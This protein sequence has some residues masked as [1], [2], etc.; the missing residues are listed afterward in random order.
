MH[1][2]FTILEWGQ[3]HKCLYTAKGKLASNTKT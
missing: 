2:L 1:F 3:R